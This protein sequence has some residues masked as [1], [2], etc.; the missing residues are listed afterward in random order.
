MNDT[1]N[2]LEAVAQGRV[3]LVLSVPLLGVDESLS[4]LSSSSLSSVTM[5]LNWSSLWWAPARSTARTGAAQTG[6]PSNPYGWSAME[7]VTVRAKTMY[8]GG[9]GGRLL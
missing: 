1:V 3:G 8:L 6:L 9:A 5:S 2:A 4:P 7:V